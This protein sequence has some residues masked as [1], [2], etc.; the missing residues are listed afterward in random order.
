MLFL[1]FPWPTE[2]HD[3]RTSLRN[4]PDAFHCEERRFGVTGHYHPV[5]R[6][7][8]Q[9]LVQFAPGPASTL[10]NSSQGWP[11]GL[12]GPHTVPSIVSMWLLRLGV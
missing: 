10:P 6:L 2:L 3:T 5:V 1:F 12:F 11:G 7:L 9:L 4:G 8:Q